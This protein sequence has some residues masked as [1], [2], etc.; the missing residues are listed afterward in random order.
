[1]SRA[2]REMEIDTSLQSIQEQIEDEVTRVAKIDGVTRRSARLLRAEGYET[3]E[4]IAKAN[5]ETLA[6]ILGISTESA[7]RIKANAAKLITGSPRSR[8]TTKRAS[9]KIKRKKKSK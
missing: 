7:A 5:V 6:Q 1:M 9:R 8:V 2:L 4:L 3:P